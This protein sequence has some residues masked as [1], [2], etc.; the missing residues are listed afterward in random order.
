MSRLS[1]GALVGVAALSA[2]AACEP[3]PPARDA[4]DVLSHLPRY[5]E[6]RDVLCARGRDN[7]ITA[8]FCQNDA[9]DV[10]GIVDLLR[11]LDLEFAG[12]S[13]P[14]FALTGHSSSLVARHVSAINPRAVIFKFP[15]DRNDG[16]FVAVAFTR[17]DQVV[18]I[19]VMP[20]GGEIDGDIQFYLLRYEQPC[21]DAEAGCTPKDTLT[22]ATETGWT[23]WSLYDDKDLENSVLDCLHC[24]QPEGPQT[25]IHFRMQELNNPWT[26]WFSGFND[27]GRALYRDYRA[28]HGSEVYAGIPPAVIGTSN[29][30]LIEQLVRRS[31]SKEPFFFDSRIIEDEI[32]ATN[33]AQPADNSVV[34]ISP[35]WQVLY[36]R[37]VAG[38]TIPP[39][40]HDVKITDP[41]KLAAMT[42]AYVDVV[43]GRDAE[44]PDIREV[45]RPEA[46]IGMS[47]VPAPG[48]D[49]HGIFRHACAQCH[50]GSL[51]QSL[52]RARFNAFDVDNLDA[53][54]RDLLIDRLVR[55]AD[56]RYVMPPSLFRELPAE[57]LKTL[58][59]FLRR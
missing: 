2:G 17:G 22:S 40:F 59:D 16:S 23:R 34:G 50:N 27:G 54:Q 56:D 44:L 5:E 32:T 1:L 51:D 9:P 52:S 13:R 8:V 11:L 53:Q 15:E 43:S 14:A 36:D 48:L 45:I 12:D 6:Q 31:N 3:P 37:A 29:P 33:A 57:D 10:A 7:A 55:Q 4:S 42:R 18:E 26:H 46:V 49:A 38:E 35:S 58:I 25:R 47:L 24:H 21:T 41:I 28:A 30:I 20:P 19:A 39:P